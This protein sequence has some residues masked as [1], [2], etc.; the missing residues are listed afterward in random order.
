MAEASEVLPA[1]GTTAVPYSAEALL[2]KYAA[3]KDAIRARLAHFR[4]IGKSAGDAQLFAELA[5]CILTPQ[6][7]AKRADAAIKELQWR[8]LLFDGEFV[9]IARVLEKNGVRFPGN[10]TKFLVETRYHLVRPGLGMRQLLARF[11][12]AVVFREWLAKNVKG[13]GYK[14][15]SH[16][17]RN[18]GRG[19]ELAILDRHILRNLADYGVIEE[20]PGSL[21]PKRYFEIE[22]KMKDFA[23]RIGIPL[24]E[25]DLLLW[26]EETGEIFK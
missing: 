26:S 7:S 20:I 1:V 4:E 5:F 17:L 23:S 3:K 14:E 21:P 19:D 18:I 13:F 24:G 8:G 2:E 11:S 16:F 15:A 12:D 22:Q 10:K 6:S 25:L 9:D